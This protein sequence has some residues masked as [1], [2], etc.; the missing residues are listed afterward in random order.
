MDLYHSYDPEKHFE[1]SNANLFKV[2]DNENIALSK[3]KN[4][5][6]RKF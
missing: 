1:S 2:P 6:W 3:A 5:E 4:D